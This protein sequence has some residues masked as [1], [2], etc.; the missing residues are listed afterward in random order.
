[1]WVRKEKGE[2]E[3]YMSLVGLGMSDGL[4]ILMAVYR[5]TGW[6][7]PGLEMVEDDDFIVFTNTLPTYLTSLQLRDTT[8]WCEAYAFNGLCS[9]VHLSLSIICAANL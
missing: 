1:M 2:E 5:Q 4:C 3:V 9:P 7:Y 6:I 8:G